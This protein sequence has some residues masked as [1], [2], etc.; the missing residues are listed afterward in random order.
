M[1]G[2]TTITITT[3]VNLDNY[4]ED[5]VQV[6]VGGEIS[7]HSAHEAGGDGA[8][9]VLI[10]HPQVMC[11]RIFFW[12]GMGLSSVLLHPSL[13]PSPTIQV[14]YCVCVCVCDR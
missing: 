1:E 7:P 14:H 6:F 13:P 3:S 12:L 2:G 8:L 9:R 5:E 11:V 10:P 4:I